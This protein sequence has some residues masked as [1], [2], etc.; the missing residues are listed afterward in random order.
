MIVLYLGIKNKTQDWA[1]IWSIF[2][3]IVFIV[4]GTAAQNKN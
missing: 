2:A 3:D 4:Y 1:R